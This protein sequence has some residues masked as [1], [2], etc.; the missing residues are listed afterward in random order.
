MESLHI[1]S[2]NDEFNPAFSQLAGPWKLLHKSIALT[3]IAVHIHEI[4]RASAANTPARPHA[5]P[6]RPPPRPLGGS[7]SYQFE[8]T[9]HTLYSVMQA[10]AGMEQHAA[11]EHLLPSSS[12][13]SS[14]SAYFLHLHH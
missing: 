4:P 14:E 12:A 9:E 10:Q 3:R 2:T 7:R 6:S 1:V 11:L 8:S 13:S 5:Y